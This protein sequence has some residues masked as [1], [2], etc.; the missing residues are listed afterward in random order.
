MSV[1]IPSPTRWV[2]IQI[3]RSLN[4]C[5]HKPLLTWMRTVY[6]GLTDFDDAPP[7]PLDDESAEILRSLGYVD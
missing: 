7:E 1:Q 6:D 2:R 3:R 4:W 5:S